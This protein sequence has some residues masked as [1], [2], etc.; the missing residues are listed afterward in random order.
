M[1]RSGINCEENDCMYVSSISND[2]A[3]TS[4]PLT[5]SDTFHLRCN[6]RSRDNHTFVAYFSYTIIAL[7]LTSYM[8][9]ET[10][11]FNKVIIILYIK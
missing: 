11:I 9:R 1:A 8:V 4:A 2:D 6:R 5:D 3:G 10:I 7:T